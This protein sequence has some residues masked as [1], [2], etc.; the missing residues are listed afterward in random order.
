M[1]SD[2]VWKKLEIMPGNC[3][4]KSA[5]KGVDY[6]YVGNILGYTEIVTVKRTEFLNVLNKC[7]MVRKQ[8]F[9]N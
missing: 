1:P 9:E 3:Q 7:E 5:G 4:V 6:R 2:R 8:N